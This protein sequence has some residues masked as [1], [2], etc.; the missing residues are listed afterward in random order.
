MGKK[1]VQMKIDNMAIK[2]FPV[3]ARELPGTETWQ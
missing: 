3:P 2:D 1:L